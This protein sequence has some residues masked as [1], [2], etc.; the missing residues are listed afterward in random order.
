MA[1]VRKYG[2]PGLFITMTCNSD[3][4]EIV[5]ELL[6]GQTARDRPD[7]TARV[8][9][10]KLDALKRLLIDDNVLGV[11]IAHVYTIEFQKRGLPHAHLLLI[12]SQQWVPHTVQD[13]DNLV[14]AEIPDK[15][16]HPHLHK[17]VTSHMMH[18]PC[19]A[20]DKHCPCMKENQC[21]KGFPKSFKEAT[22]IGD[23]SYPEYKRYEC[24]ALTAVHIST[25]H[26]NNIATVPFLCLAAFAWQVLTA[27]QLTQHGRHM[28]L[29]VICLQ[30]RQQPHDIQ[31]VQ[32]EGRACAARQQICG[33]IQPNAADNFQLP[34]EC[35]GVCQHQGCQV[36]VQVRLQG[37]R[38]R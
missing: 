31:V 37:P 11:C 18:G 28:R 26:T 13:I 3:W 21:S 4:P 17:C 1:L 14:S 10:M 7:L 25:A 24:P 5:A 29:S 6:D 8:F 9:A 22:T 19:G 12:L 27:V 16:T 33:S 34:H 30:A 36:S 38:S 32:A 20:L 2:K 15:D 23:D 35:G